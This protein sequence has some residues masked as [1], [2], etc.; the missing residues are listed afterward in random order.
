MAIRRLG[1]AHPASRRYC[2]ISIKDPSNEVSVVAAETRPHYAFST[3]TCS[4][5]ATSLPDDDDDWMLLQGVEDCTFVLSDWKEGLMM[6]K[7]EAA[8]LRLASSSPY[9]QK[10]LCFGRSV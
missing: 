9:I 5:T 1:A 2:G 4:L 7:A 8:T 6:L 10:F 3:L